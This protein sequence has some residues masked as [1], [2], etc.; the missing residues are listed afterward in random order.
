MIYFFIGLILGIFLSFV[1][2]LYRHNKDKVLIQKFL[3]NLLNDNYYFTIDE[4]NKSS[5]LTLIDSLRKKLLK[6]NF[7]FQVLFTKIY[8]VSHNLSST[9]EYVSSSTELLYEEANTLSETNNISSH[10]VN[11]TLNIIRE[12]SSLFEN[13]KDTS[14]NISITSDESQQII[15]KGLKDIL[16]IVSS[17]QE[18]KSSTDE[19]MKNIKGLKQI[20]IEISSILNTVNDIASQTH[21]L[22][23]NA[24]IE[25]ARAGEYGKGFSVVAKEISNLAENSKNSVLEISKLIEKIQKQIEIVIETSIPN[26]KNVER[27]VTYS[28]NIE[29]ILNKIKVSVAAIVNSVNEIINITDKEYESIKNMNSKCN[30]VQESFEVIS[31]NVKNMYSSVKTQNESIKELKE[32]QKFLIDT[33]SSLD[34]FCEKIEKD[35]AKLNTDKVKIRCSEIITLIK[36]DLLSNYKLSSLDENIHKKLL[37]KFSDKHSYVEAIWTNDNMGKFIYSNPPNGI[38]NANV[39]KW[40]EESIKGKE[41]ISDVYISAITANPCV[42]VSIP[43]V[44]SNNIITGVIG[45]DLKI[46]V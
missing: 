18:I 10:K 27:S 5:Y 44:D 34:S 42:T 33:S 26:E 13:I 3:N 4:K 30:E 22:S 23:L 2:F 7:K 32:M 17:I 12:I 15:M 1:V 41:Y 46:D 37:C 40:F 31:S 9:I 35:I 29:N 21:M 43:I 36:K 20:S 8:S 24:S 14:K 38:A 25:A 6:T 16:G 45:I 11:D 39:R 28:Q 19:T